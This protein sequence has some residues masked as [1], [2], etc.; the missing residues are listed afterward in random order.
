MPFES[1]QKGMQGGGYG[2]PYSQAAA[3]R[4]F[5]EKFYGSWGK[6]QRNRY[7]GLGNFDR[8]IELRRFLEVAIGLPLGEMELA[9]QLAN[10]V[11]AHQLTSQKT[12]RGVQMLSL[13]RFGGARHLP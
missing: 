13:F 10:C 6:L 12:T 2:C 4:V 1:T 5:P 8:A 7:C 9:R 3:F 11:G